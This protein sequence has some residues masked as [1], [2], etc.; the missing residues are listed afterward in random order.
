MGKSLLTLL[1]VCLFGVFTA[2]AQD[3]SSA[4]SQNAQQGSYSQST[5]TNTQSTTTTQGMANAGQ[6]SSTAP[7][8]TQSAMSNGATQTSNAGEQ[9]VE[10]CLMHQQ[11]SYFVQPENGGARVQLS[12]SRSLDSYVGQHVRISGHN[13]SEA[14]DTSTA[15]SSGGASD[16]GS[17]MLTVTSVQTISA[18]CSP[19]S[20]PTR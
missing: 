10:G 9:T 7:S 1:V 4:A 8:S 16:L 14:G 3:N 19:A 15:V 17:G 18:T 5:T 2:M 20:T 6:S 11:T 12:P 13:G